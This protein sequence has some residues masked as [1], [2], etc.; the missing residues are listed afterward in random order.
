M[1]GLV[2]GGNDPVGTSAQKFV[3]ALGHTTDD[4]T[5]LLYMRARYMDPAVGRFTSEDPGEQ[6]SNWFVYCG[7]NP[8]NK[9]GS[10]EYI[11]LRKT[12]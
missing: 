8:V 1:Y 12:A 5:G 2:R 10:D 11:L 4:K 6:G 7:N 3:G 9:D